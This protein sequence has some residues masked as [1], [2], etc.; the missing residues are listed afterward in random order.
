MKWKSKFES[1][2]KHASSLA[3]AAVF[4]LVPVQAFA[5]AANQTQIDT[6]INAILGLLTG[7]IAKGLATIA[8][9]VAGFMFFFGHGNKLLLGSIILGCFIVFGAGWVVSTISGS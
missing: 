2:W 7:T 5:Q 4:M 3:T 1:R 8:L 9:V 6:M